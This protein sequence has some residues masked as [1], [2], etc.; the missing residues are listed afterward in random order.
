VIPAAILEV[1]LGDVEV[2]TIRHTYD[3]NWRTVTATAKEASM[4]IWKYQTATCGPN[5]L[6]M[7]LDEMAKMGW[8]IIAVLVQQSDIIHPSTPAA[9][10]NHAEVV[11][12]REIVTEYRIIAKQ[13]VAQYPPET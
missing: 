7:S 2:D 1:V 9:A 12:E 4:A 6:Q 10:N 11:L 8:E 5:D 13:Q 3:R